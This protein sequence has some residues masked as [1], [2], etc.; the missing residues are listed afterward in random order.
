[1]KKA[2]IE[3]PDRDGKGNLVIS[4]SSLTIKFNKKGFIKTKIIKLETFEKKIEKGK[5]EINKKGYGELEL[6]L[7]LKDEDVSFIVVKMYGVFYLVVKLE[8]F[9]T[10]TFCLHF[11]MEKLE[12]AFAEL[13]Q[14]LSGS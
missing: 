13:K 3:I 5:R 2:R 11:Q 9:P 1:M 10:G 14:Y 7:P 6:K 8:T 12:T 4:E